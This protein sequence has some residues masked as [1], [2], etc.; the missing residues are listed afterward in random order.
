MLAVL[1]DSKRPASQG[2]MGYRKAYLMQPDSTVLFVM[3]AMHAKGRPCLRL[4]ESINLFDQDRSRTIGIVTKPELPA[5]TEIPKS[6]L[7]DLTK[8]QGLPLQHGWHALH[9]AGKASTSTAY[10]TLA[11]AEAAFFAEERSEILSAHAGA[12]SL[13]NTLTV[14]HEARLRKKIP[15]TIGA[16]K[17]LCTTIEDRRLANPPSN[18]IMRRSHLQKASQ[19][20][21]NLIRRG[22]S[23]EAL[24]DH[25]FYITA[26]THA[27]Q[28]K[29]RQ[30]V[31]E[32]KS[33]FRATLE[34]SQAGYS[35][36]F[37]VDKDRYI[38]KVLS[39]IQ[40]G[41]LEVLS[42]HGSTPLVNRMFIRQVTPWHDIAKKH[43][44]LIVS[45]AKAFLSAVLK[46]VFPEV[47]A[48]EV[49]QLLVAPVMAALENKTMTRL[50]EVIDPYQ[51][52]IL[53][54]LNDHYFRTTLRE[55][56]CPVGSACRTFVDNEDD[57]DVLKITNTIS[58]E[59]EK[60]RDYASCLAAVNV[61][62]THYK[63]RLHE[64]FHGRFS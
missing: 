23:C 19:R 43:C 2:Q 17:T 18:D 30:L 32:Q 42:G 39:D 16:A 28:N 47:M 9:G 25:D 1:Q 15:K 49:E 10:T 4:Q 44:D 54:T 20:C 5:M 33:A 8:H 22:A 41:T 37:G 38:A 56:G 58:R 6:A 61:M 36:V 64:S 21:Q 51:S 7:T 62:L 48:V 57:R 40:H 3:P 26:G 53:V 35:K 34:R 60:K 12:R 31:E 55:L 46:S 13:L 52:G 29:L 14:M 59:L 45:A 11:E 50:Q 63:V 24:Y 27:S